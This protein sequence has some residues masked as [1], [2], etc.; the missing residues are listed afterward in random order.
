MNYTA[1]CTKPSPMLHEYAEVLVPR[2]SA[3][4]SPAAWQIH[5]SHRRHLGQLQS[6]A[7]FL[8]YLF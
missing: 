7:C 8:P 5:Y 3:Y 6:S 4:K 1:A 2:L